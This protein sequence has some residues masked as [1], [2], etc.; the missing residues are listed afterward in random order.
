MEAQVFTFN[1]SESRSWQS[2]MYDTFDCEVKVV[3]FKVEDSQTLDCLSRLNVE[4]VGPYFVYKQKYCDQIEILDLDTSK[5][6]E[7]ISLS[8]MIEEEKDAKY[9]NFFQVPKTAYASVKSR[10]TEV[11]RV[12][13]TNLLQV[14]VMNQIFIYDLDGVYG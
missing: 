11:D 3:L 9:V 6:L 2:E 14:V 12:Y 7:P 13:Y 10:R 4:I 5:N 1:S 8:N